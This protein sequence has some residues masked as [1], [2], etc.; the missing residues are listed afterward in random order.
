[1]ITDTF[2]LF[3]ILDFSPLFNVLHH[4]LFMDFLFIASPYQFSEIKSSRADFARCL[5]YIVDLSLDAGFI[6]IWC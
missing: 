1:M 5:N 3:K 6:P 4:S 2:N